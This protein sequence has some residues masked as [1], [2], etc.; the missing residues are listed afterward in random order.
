MPPGQ[1]PDLLSLPL[2]QKKNIWKT[3][4][5]YIPELLTV[6]LGG[7]LLRPGQLQ[8]VLP[9]FSLEANEKKRRSPL[10]KVTFALSLDLFLDSNERPPW[11]DE[12]SRRWKRL[13]C[14][15]RNQP[16][17]TFGECQTGRAA[18]GAVHLKAAILGRTLQNVSINKAF[19]V[20][21]VA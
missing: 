15:V 7:P 1:K 19:L 13:P 11:H 21:L 17:W 2:H 3:L 4:F 8:Y 10:C 12:T 18:V 20:F 16:L 14:W 6:G 5:R 9:S